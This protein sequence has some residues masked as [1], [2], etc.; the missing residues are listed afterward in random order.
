MSVSPDEILCYI[1]VQIFEEIGAENNIYISKIKSVQ[2]GPAVSKTTLSQLEFRKKVFKGLAGNLRN[3]ITLKRGKPNSS[4]VEDR[5]NGKLHLIQAQDWKA[6]KDCAIFSNRE[7]KGGRRETSFCCDTC[8]SRQGLHPNKC[9]VPSG[10]LLLLLWLYGPLLD[11]GCF[12]QFLN[13]NTV[14]RTPWT[15]DQ[16]VERPL[17]IPRTTQTQN[18]HTQYRHPCVEWDSNP[19]S[20]RSS[21]RRKFQS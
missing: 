8:P 4:D 9:E 14:G 20:H 11:L 16:P 3:K 10:M 2:Y 7:A 6:K 21:E 12:F 5:L 17:P 1:L 19:Q 18:K 13:L 15:G